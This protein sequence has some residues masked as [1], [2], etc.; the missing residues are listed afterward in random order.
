MKLPELLSP[1]GSYEKMLAAF[2]YGAD[3][4]YLA[5]ED[6]GMRSAAKN[7]S[8]EEIR[9]A[10]PYAHALGKKVYVAVNVLPHSN[11]YPA[12]RRFL[13]ALAKDPPDGLIISDI[14]VIETAR[15]LIP[16]AEIHLSTQ[17]S[18]VSAA[19]CRAWH[20]L[21]VK[22]VVLAR[23]LT[24]AEIAFIR[25]STP[26]SLEL[27]AFIH[28]SMCVSYSGRCLL[29]Q[30]LAGRDS[31]RGACTQPCRW[32][33]VIS[34][35]KHQSEKLPVYED[36]GTFILSSRDLSMIEHIPELVE[37]GLSSLK[38]EG[39]MKSAYYAA[40]TANTYRMALDAYG[41]DP[42][43]Y[44]FDPRWKEELDSVSHRAYSTGYYFSS[45]FENVNTVTEDGYIREKAYL[46]EA[47]ADTNEN[48][49]TLFLQHNKFSVGDTVELL[50]P[51]RPG[52]PF[53]VS[54][55]LAEDGSPLSSVPHPKQRFLL[56]LPRPVRKG[57]ILRGSYP[58]L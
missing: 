13:R 49:L 21:G 31:N 45:L 35:E 23:E 17:A 5:G 20:R 34:E 54:A 7:F 8:L 53:S 48:G 50:E 2:R 32:N 44:R 40:V 19:A 16:A 9:A 56:S 22:R 29:S 42:A 30:Y 43:R 3:A 28:G 39:R 33:F 25:R 38:I 26:R 14:G 52:E 58:H 1:A 15:E 46:A 51:G 10:I 57:S 55:L 18:A 36:R 12:L 27:E 6:F 37:A 41:R 24:L 47:I 4:V 11:E